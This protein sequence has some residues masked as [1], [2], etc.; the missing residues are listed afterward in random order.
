M[1]RYKLRQGKLRFDDSGDWVRRAE[2]E[3]LTAEVKRL[4]TIRDAAEPFLA[5]PPADMSDHIPCNQYT[6]AAD[7]REL[8]AAFRTYYC[9]THKAVDAAKGA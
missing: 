1:Q 2:V 8:S 7:C 3:R 5:D 9:E 6:T 4:Q